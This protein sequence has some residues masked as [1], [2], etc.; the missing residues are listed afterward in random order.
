M[1]Y[2]ELVIREFVDI[3]GVEPTHYFESGGRLEL[4]GNHTDHNHGTCLVAGC[5]LGIYAAVKKTRDNIIHIVSK[6]FDEIYIDLS[7]LDGRKE[8][9]FTSK[10]IIR[11]VAAKF[12][13]D[14]RNIGG[15][16]A[17]LD[18]SIFIGAGVSSSASFELLIAKILSAFYNNDAL[19]PLELAKIAHY[20]ETKYFGKPCGLLDQI[21]I[22]FGGVNFL[23]FK[24]D[25]NPI[26][27]PLDFDLPLRIFLV[28]T[29]ASHE[30]LSHLYAS[31]KDDMLLVA[32]RVF[33]KPFLRDVSKDDFFR[34]IAYPIDGVSELQKLRAQHFI[35]ELDRVENAKQAIIHKD[36]IGFLTAVRQSSFSS[37]AFLRNTMYGDYLT[38]P[39]RGLDIASSLLEEG[40]ARIHGGGFAGTIICFLK[41]WEVDRFVAA[42]SSIF[43]EDKVVEVKIREEGVSCACLASPSK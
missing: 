8:E 11:G 10:G 43:G 40:A 33:H 14:R 39:Q 1:S 9:F 29:G 5:D 2:R 25:V 28:H 34:L 20:S 42:M 32:N 6:G 21:G 23:D 26:I 30:G 19:S 13:I 3:F 35:D 36:A 4:L 7:D 22:A 12:V 17:Y 27:E 38:S 24:D 41:D 16:D 31:I 15:F 18:S 37:S